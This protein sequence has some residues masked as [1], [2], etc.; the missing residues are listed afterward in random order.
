MKAFPGGEGWVSNTTHYGG[1][2][3]RRM[4]E[5]NP[6]DQPAGCAFVYN[7]LMASHRYQVTYFPTD[8][9]QGSRLTINHV[10]KE[11]SGFYV[12]AAK[13]NYGSDVTSIHLMVLQLP[14]APF[15]F[16]VVVTGVEWAELRWKE[17]FHGNSEIVEYLVEIYRE[18]GLW[19][20]VSI[21]CFCIILIIFIFIFI[22]WLLSNNNISIFKLISIFNYHNINPTWRLRTNS[23]MTSV[24]WRFYFKIPG[25]TRWPQWKWRLLSDQWGWTNW[26]QQQLTRRG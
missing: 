8:K 4:Q 26:G 16:G 19:I 7:V 23:T 10:T 18:G 25:K 20:G 5:R 15:D 21:F 13:N 24:V 11:D 22:K 12:C 17:G 1:C 14:D 3:Y 9:G 2:H 6:F